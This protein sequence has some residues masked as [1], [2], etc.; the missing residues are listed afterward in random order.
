MGEKAHV[1]VSILDVWMFG[2]LDTRQGVEAQVFT[3][4]EAQG[5]V[6]GGEKTKRR[7]RAWF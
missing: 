3:G 5:R 6:V 7:R 1:D 4:G 2:C